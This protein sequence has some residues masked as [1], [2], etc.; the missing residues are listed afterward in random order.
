MGR[1]KIPLE[2]ITQSLVKETFLYKDGFLYWK[3]PKARWVKVGDKVGHTR[4]DNYV[5]TRVF[6]RTYLIHRLVWFYH[7]GVWPELIDHID[8]NPQNNKI[9]NLRVSN[10]I[11]NSYNSGLPKNNTSGIRGI[12]RVNKSW[13]ACAKAGK[14]Y[15]RRSFKCL[16]Q[17]IKFRKQTLERSLGQ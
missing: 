11:Y 15:I 13:T 2:K 9:E 16:G 3:R 6:G 4:K 8:R 12:V 17:A 14:T 10:K 5:V 1:V 7:Y